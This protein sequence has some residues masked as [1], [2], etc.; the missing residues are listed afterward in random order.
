LES[1]KLRK[2]GENLELREF[3]KLGSLDSLVILESCSWS[4]NHSCEV[5]RRV[6]TKSSE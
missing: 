6:I 4:Y 2:C 1:K 3:K 5:S